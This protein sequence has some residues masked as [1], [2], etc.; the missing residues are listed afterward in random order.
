MAEILSMY[1]THKLNVLKELFL[2][3]NNF[4]ND[5]EFCKRL[6]SQASFLKCFFFPNTALELML[7]S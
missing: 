2:N 6:P 4:V 5:V 1:L 3:W 7:R